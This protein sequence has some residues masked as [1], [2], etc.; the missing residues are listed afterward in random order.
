M[1]ILAAVA[2]IIFT[3]CVPLFLITTNARIVINAPALYSYGFDR[4]DI[5]EL[6]GVERSE[7]I[8]A[9]SQ[10]REY[11]NNDEE[12]L[13]VRIVMWGTLSRLFNRKEI[14]HMKDVKSLVQ[15][16]YWTQVATGLYLLAFTA[17]AVVLYKRR[18]LP[19]LASFLSIGGL[20]TLVLVLAVGLFALFGF[21]TA[22]TLFHRLS[23][24]N[25]LWMLDPGTDFLKAMFPDGF[26]FDATMIIAGATVLEAVLLT[27]I[28]PVFLRK[29][30]WSGLRAKHTAIPEGQRD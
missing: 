2:I 1:R 20:A 9:A 21:D 23:F 13:D 17:G 29:A 15:G 28:T 5:P 18:A 4:Y 19:K 30:P 16:V 11:F 25:E 24:G 27:A 26:F 10:I 7:L 14:E 6:T 22:F 3:L 12:Y 8:S